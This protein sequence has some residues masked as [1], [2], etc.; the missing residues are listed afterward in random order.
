MSKSIRRR[1]HGFRRDQE[2]GY[3]TDSFFGDRSPRIEEFF[4]KDKCRLR[5]LNDDD[6][7]RL[8][9]IARIGD[10]CDRVGDSIL[11]WG[12]LR[13]KEDFS[14][15]WIEGE[16]LDSAI[17][18][19]SYRDIFRVSESSIHSVVRKE[20]LIPCWTVWV[21]FE[22][23]FCLYAWFDWVFFGSRRDEYRLYTDRDKW[24]LELRGR[25]GCRSGR[26]DIGW[27]WS[28]T[29]SSTRR[30]RRWCHEPCVV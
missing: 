30:L 1:E 18:E 29:R 7:N 4:R 25:D 21:V 24:L 10:I 15:F 16:T 19:K 2:V 23:W 27:S 8:S 6:S 5:A 17:I 22:T 26:R 28:T 3:D 9:S 11:S 20:R 12:C 13:R 14:C